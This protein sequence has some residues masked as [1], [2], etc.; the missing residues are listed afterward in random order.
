MKF[1]S[2]LHL[3]KGLPGACKGILAVVAP[4]AGEYRIV[5]VIRVLDAPRTRTCVGFVLGT[6]GRARLP[7]RVMQMV[8]ALRSSSAMRAAA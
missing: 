8:P 7:A 4:C 1:T 6:P 2:P 3:H 5:R